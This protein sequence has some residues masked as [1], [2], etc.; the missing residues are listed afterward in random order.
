MTSW[1]DVR[2]RLEDELRTLDDA[3]FVVVAEPEPPRPPARGLLHRRPAAAPVRY[4]QVR[5][6]GEHCYAECVGATSFGGD[7]DVDDATHARLRELGWRV[8]GDEDP[9]GVEPSYPHYWKL[10]PRIEADRVASLCADSLA[11]L[12]AD[13]S[14]LQW[15]RE[16]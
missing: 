2:G 7:W 14:T 12:G 1:D 3:S 6:D 10:L 15:R 16:S 13:A 4:V 8:P 11:L 5:R 9:S